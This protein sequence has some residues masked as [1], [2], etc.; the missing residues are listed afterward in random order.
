MTLCSC[1]I[2]KVEL[3]VLFVSYI[4][5]SLIP[6]TFENP[7][8][9]FLSKSKFMIL[10]WLSLKDLRICVD[11]KRDIR[12]LKETGILGCAVKTETYGIYVSG[13][14]HDPPSSN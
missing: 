11:S 3:K 12:C 4:V 7:E 13:E 5:V 8:C 9:K 2:T 6:I 14:K 10:L 1:F